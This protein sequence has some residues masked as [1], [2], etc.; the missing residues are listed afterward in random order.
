[1]YNYYSSLHTTT[2]KIAVIVFACVAEKARCL[3]KSC[4]HN[5]FF[6]IAIYRTGFFIVFKSVSVSVLESSLLTCH[7]LRIANLYRQIH[8]F[9]LVLFQVVLCSKLYEFCFELLALCILSVWIVI[10]TSEIRN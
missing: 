4:F 9:I 10:L 5:F 7:S 1:M 3:I 6:P 2:D 8:L